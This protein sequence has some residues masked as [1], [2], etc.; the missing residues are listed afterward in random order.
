M[1][2]VLEAIDHMTASE[3]LRTLEY[4]WGAICADAE[5]MPPAWHADV[6][7]A[8]K[9]RARNGSE[10]FLTIEESKRRLKEAAHAN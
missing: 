5:P 10:G 4:L 1:A 3:R 6:L 2:N 9:A 8:R 7:A